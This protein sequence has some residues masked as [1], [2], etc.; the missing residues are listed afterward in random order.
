MTHIPRRA[1]SPFPESHTSVARRTRQRF[2]PAE[3]GYSH[4]LGFSNLVLRIFYHSGVIL[5][6]V[7]QY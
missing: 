4:N 3:M 1:V 2:L 6:Q 7:V 5:M